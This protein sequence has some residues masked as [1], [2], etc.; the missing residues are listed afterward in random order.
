MDRLQA[1]SPLPL[2]LTWHENRST[3][4][5][6][7]KQRTHLHLRLHRLFLEAPTPVLEALIQMALNRRDRKA[8]G[9]VRSMAHLYFSQHQIAAAPLSSQGAVYNLQSIYEGIKKRYFPDDL[10]VSI[11]WSRKNPPRRKY[12]SITFGTYNRHSSQIRINRLLDD[13]RVPLYFV[14]FIV[15][16]EMLHDVCPV[17]MDREGRCRMHTREFRAKEKLFEQYEAAKLWEKTS[18]QFFSKK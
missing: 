11:G 14:E 9:I 18:L 4:L 10:T 13:A 5:S 3:Y 12:R 7:R 16:H 2:T 8:R 1:L 17:S 6:I 15:Y